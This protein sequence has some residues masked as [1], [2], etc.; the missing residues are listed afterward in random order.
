[1]T[2]C[3]GSPDNFNGDPRDEGLLLCFEMRGEQREPKELLVESG[4]ALPAGKR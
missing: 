3:T 2:S 1:M 4:G